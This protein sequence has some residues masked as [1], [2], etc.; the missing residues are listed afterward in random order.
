MEILKIGKAAAAAA[1]AGF[2]CVSANA[3]QQ[4]GQVIGVH[5][6]ASDGLI[7]FFITGSAAGRP[8]CAT[9]PYWIIKNETSTTGR[10][11]LAQLLAARASGATITV[12]GL[13][14]CTRWGDGED[15]D[16]ITF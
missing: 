3:G 8:G 10:Q 9:Q 4:T 16:E 2:L 11:Q 5:V 13:N 12:T 14:T 6:R 1:L 7:Y 15:V